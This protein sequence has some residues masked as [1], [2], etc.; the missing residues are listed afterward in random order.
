MD[1]SPVPLTPAT[2]AFRAQVRDWLDEHV[3]PEMI[4]SE[5]RLGEG[6]NPAFHRALGA[7]GWAFPALPAEEGGA[8]LSPVEHRILELELAARHV[9]TVMRDVTGV[10]MVAVR[11]WLAE[12]LR[13][14]LLREAARGETCFCLGYTEPEAGSDLAAVKTRAER[15]GDGWIV[16]GQKMFTTGATHCGY[17][18]LLT[19]TDSSGPKHKGLTT[20]LM[21]LDRPGIEIQPIATLG[22]ERTN[23]VFYDDVQVEDDYRLGPAGEGWKVVQ[24]ALNVE[25]RMSPDG[26]HPVE[27]EEGEAGMMTGAD[28]STRILRVEEPA[29][30]DAVGWASTPGPGGRR[31][32]DDP[33]VRDRLAEAELGV[34]VTRVTPG[35]HGR[36][37]AAD[38]M[39]RTVADLFDLVG[40]AALAGHGQDV[41]VG[42]GWI[43][44]AQRFAQ[45]TAIYGGTTEIFRNLIAEHFLGLG[46]RQRRNA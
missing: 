1:F 21:P 11:Q 8:D 15:H 2:L 27:E 18:L 13:T 35:P 16:N 3:T 4:E 43:E 14:E 36:V 30:R 37:V 29:L 33:R 9:P 5:W 26:P 24:G 44:Y 7:R 38:T 20:F 10:V 45:G 41:T 12:P 46:T 34:E 31:P 22:G 42:D 39:I 25:H 23:I 6:H 32:L 19:R 17:S 40:P 28:M